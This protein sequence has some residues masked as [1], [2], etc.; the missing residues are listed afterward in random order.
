MSGKDTI[1]LAEGRLVLEAT[2]FPRQIDSLLAENIHFHFTRQSDGRDIRLRNSGVVLISQN[3][4]L[5]EWQATDSSEELRMDLRASFR[6]GMELHYEVKLSVLQDLELKELTLHIPVRPAGDYTWREDSTHADRR[7]VVIIAGRDL[8][9]GYSLQGRIWENEGK[10]GITVGVKGR[11]LLANNYTGQHS[12][13]K[14]DV[15]EYDFDLKA[16][17]VFTP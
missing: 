14:G 4:N 9:F 11:S 10:G 15:L 8:A 16:S 12:M 3:R 2:G 7:E 5:V 1:R 6:A 17:G 13:K